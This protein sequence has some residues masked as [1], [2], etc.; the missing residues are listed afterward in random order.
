LLGKVTSIERNGRQGGSFD[1]LNSSDGLGRVLRFSE[2]AT[3][4]FVRLATLRRA[5]TD[6]QDERIEWHAQR[7]TAAAWTWSSTSVG[8]SS[9]CA[10]TIPPS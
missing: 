1:W 6:E 3:V 4:L 2:W 9:G 5:L 10:S 8:C 7:S